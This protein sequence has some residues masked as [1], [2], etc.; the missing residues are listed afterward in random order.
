MNNAGWN[1]GLG[2]VIIRF[3][4]LSTNEPVFVY[5]EKVA[6]FN[7]DNTIIESQPKLIA[8]RYKFDMVFQNCVQ[9]M[10]DLHK[11]DYSIVILADQD[12]V[13]KGLM[14]VEDMRYKFDCFVKLLAEKHIPVIGIFTVKNNCFRKPHTWCWRMLMKFY[15]SNK[16]T[17]NLKESF[18]CGNLAGRA[19]KN[20]HKRD[21]DFIDR[22]FAHNIGVEFKVP[23]QVFRHTVDDRELKY[24]NILDDTEKDEY[25][26]TEYERYKKSVYYN[27][28]GA[29]DSLLFYCYDQSKKFL[30][31]ASPD[32]KIVSKK[33]SFMII[34]VGPPS[35]GKTFLANILARKASKETIG[36]NGKKTIRSEFIIINDK[37]IIDGKKLSPLKREA[38]LNEAIL[39][40]RLIILDG[41]Y[42]SHDSRKPYMEKAAEFNMPVIFFK[43]DTT[44]RMCRHFNHMKFEERN[45]Y[46][47]EPL[48]L[49]MFK[50]YNKTY[51]TPDVT[52]YKAQIPKLNVLCINIPTLILDSKEFRNIY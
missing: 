26:K 19:A 31:A 10:Q 47:K 48:S 21:C 34:M 6:G 14:S 51:Q 52:T 43:F 15:E 40:E 45:D 41:N 18:Y 8:D 30:S 36:A 9:K 25:M 5:R 20:S 24:E 1:E 13:F 44:Y 39:A 27:K 32:E 29:F 3:P 42:S 28:Q 38:I 49:Y 16:K 46:T 7:L 22:A 23:E 33:I 35:C 37:H 4:N 17:V 11:Q 2:G 12:G 50:K